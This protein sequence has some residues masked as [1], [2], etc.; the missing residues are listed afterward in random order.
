MRWHKTSNYSVAAVDADYAVSRAVVVNDIS[1]ELEDRFS[2]WFGPDLLQQP[3][4]TSRP[5]ELL[6]ILRTAAEAA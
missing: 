5:A 2:A 1:G 3:R 6:G 4:E